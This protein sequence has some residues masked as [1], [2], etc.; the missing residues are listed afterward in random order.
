MQELLKYCDTRNQE[1]KINMLI[2]CGGNQSEAARRLGMSYGAFGRDIRKIK[3][4]QSSV[5]IDAHQDPKVAAAGHH[6]RQAWTR[7]NPDGT[8]KEQV[9]HTI[10]D[11]EQSEAFHDFVLTE[12]QNIK[13][14]EPTPLLSKDFTPDLVAVYMFADDHIGMLCHGDQVGQNRNT[15]ISVKV[16]DSRTQMLAS[17]TPR[18]SRAVICFNGDTF[19]SDN[20]KQQT[21]ASGHQL[22]C[23]SRQE[24]IV[25]KGQQSII[26]QI[27]LLSQHHE[28]VDVFFVPGNHN[29]AGAFWMKA[30][31]YHAFINDKRVNVNMF[32]GDYAFWACGEVGLVFHHGHKTKLK[33]MTEWIE[34]NAY[35]LL[36]KC[37]LVHGHIGH[38]HT[39]EQYKNIYQH[40]NIAPQDSYGYGYASNTGSGVRANDCFIYNTKIGA[41]HGIVS[42]CAEEV[43]AELGLTSKDNLM[44]V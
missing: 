9:I 23:D 22:D 39:R 5:E 21:D 1:N 20:P 44:G 17:K 28:I 35:D 7:R 13:P 2:E 3:A 38:L 24:V 25:R 29:E 42:V 37:S 40:P 34:S 18:T 10:R 30:I 11:A 6:I 43:N 31:L 36:R 15:D 19:H 27:Q 26:H 33:K 32:Q 4:R 14:L 8:I 16:M 41:L 12:C